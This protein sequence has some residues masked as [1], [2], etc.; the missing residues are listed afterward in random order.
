MGNA[1]PKGMSWPYWYLVSFLR[2]YTLIVRERL[3][4]AQ[5]LF[6]IKISRHQRTYSALAEAYR[7]LLQVPRIAK[8][9]VL[10]KSVWG[11][12]LGNLRKIIGTLLMCRKAFA[13]L[14]I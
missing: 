14:P 5:S 3:I 12:F 10:Q 13:P 1:V 4:S 2:A 8:H 11:C 7:N 6:N 9:R